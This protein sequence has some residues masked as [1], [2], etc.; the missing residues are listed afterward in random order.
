MH[1]VYQNIRYACKGGGGGSAAWLRALSCAG[2]PQAEVARC[3]AE[4]QER[5]MV[6][7][8]LQSKRDNVARGVSGKVRRMK[9]AQELVKTKEIVG[10]DLKKAHKEAARRVTDFQQ[11]YE[12]VKNQRNKFVNLIQVSAPLCESASR[13]LRNHLCLFY[14][15]EHSP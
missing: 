14:P 6:I 10:W 15:Y 13:V 7:K 11:L 4:E 12:L 2:V 8:E 1:A 5:L 3:R 9:D